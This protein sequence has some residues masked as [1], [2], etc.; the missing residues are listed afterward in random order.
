MSS[1][2]NYIT[3]DHLLNTTYAMLTLTTV[4]VLARIVTTQLVRSKRWI[5]QDAFVYLAFVLYIIMAVLYILVTP[6]LFRLTAVGEKRLK[7]YPNLKD[8]HK[9]M[10][11]VFFVNSM[12]LWF[13]LWSIKFSFL[14]LYNK[15]MKGL[16]D[17]YYKLWCAVSVFSFLALVGCVIS[18]LTACSSLKAWFTP[19]ACQT[20]RDVRSQI[21]SLYYAYAVD[22]LTDLMIMGLPIRLIWNLQMPRTQKIGVMT[23]FGIGTILITIATLRVVQ[24]GSKAQSSSQPSASW[25]ALWGIIECSI[26]VIIGCCPSFVSLIRNRTTPGVSYN[27]Q[28]FVRQREEIAQ[29]DSKEG[30]DSV[31]L[32]SINTSVTKSNASKSE[33][34]FVEADGSQFR[35]VNGGRDVVEDIVVERPE[36]RKKIRV[37]RGA[38]G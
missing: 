18:H 1:R 2:Q 8:E 37:R 36:G 10:V 34:D 19:G 5:L 3:E 33:L 16:R 27:T 26:A 14:V 6:I 24:I 11:R 17:M 32:K 38:A 7:P 4:F 22:V 9:F 31:K 28:G 21:A 35:L 20:P 15:L 13:I 12:M 25:L 23:L 30:P 29:A